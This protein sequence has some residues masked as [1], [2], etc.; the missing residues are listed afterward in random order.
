MHESASAIR[1]IL[2][3]DSIAIVGASGSLTNPATNLMAT[4]LSS[5][6]E[7]KIYPIHPKDK[8]SLG[9]PVYPNVSAVPDPVDLAVIV[10]PSRAVPE[11]LRDCGEKGVKSAVV[12][13]AGYREMG[14]A[15]AALEQEL[16]E[17]AKQYGIR[18]IGPNCIGI[19]NTR[20][21]LNCSMFYHEGTPGGV[22][23]VSQSG[24]YITQ[25]LPY[26]QKLGIALSSAISAGNQTDIDIADTFYYFAEDDQ[27]AV[28]AV[29]L[30]G[31]RDG[32]KFFDAARTL[33]AKK[34]VV[35]LYVGGSEA[36]SRAGKSHTGA[37]ATPDALMD[38]VFAQTGVIRARTVEEL[39]DFSL[40]FSVQPLP[41]GDRVAVLTNS[42]GPGVSMADAAMR[43]G[44]RVPEFSRGFQDEIRSISI[45]TTQAG[46]PIDVTMDFDIRRLFIEI[47][48][49]VIDSGEADAILFYG[50][51]GGENFYKKFQ[52]IGM[53]DREMIEGYEKYYTSVLEEFVE[54]TK[55]AGIPVLTSSFTGRGDTPVGRMMDLGIPTYA[56]PERASAALSAMVRYARFKEKR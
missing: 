20:K 47:T 16:H 1:K 27:T 25:P 14:K 13:T 19:I 44:L 15:G 5:G 50:V 28:V 45:P 42:G 3:P 56:T 4:I 17:T 51:F 26:F 53:E 32:G 8:V 49:R 30:E 18:F 9:L 39:F 41:R 52:K 12:I 31:I 55:K 46:N 34:P 35:V 36:G 22:G 21:R 29:Y 33:S 54:L 2:N 40:A 23:L 37:I 48:G 38:A 11:V 7:G 24:S 43:L 6:Y 10:V